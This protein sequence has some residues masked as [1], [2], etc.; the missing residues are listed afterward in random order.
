MPMFE[1]MDPALMGMIG[2]TMASGMQGGGNSLGDTSMFMPGGGMGGGMRDI[3]LAQ[4]Y[5]ANPRAANLA[6]A[7][8]EA[9][10]KV[11][12]MGPFTGM[13]SGIVGGGLLGGVAGAGLG[14]ASQLGSTDKNQRLAGAIGGGALGALLGGA[15]GGQLTR[16]WEAERRRAEAYNA[17]LQQL[18][19]ARN[20]VTA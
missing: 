19:E 5:K 8:L 7:R 4:L 2:G 12:A 15:G 9:E 16:S 18:G 1:G 20:R 6:A 3:G 10:A 11:N 13:G 17:A 14:Y